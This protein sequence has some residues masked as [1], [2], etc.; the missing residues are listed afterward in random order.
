MHEHSPWY[1]MTIGVLGWGGGVREV[2]PATPTN[3]GQSTFIRAHL[4]CVRSQSEKVTR[5]D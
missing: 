1:I 3:L 2:D 4:F 5:V